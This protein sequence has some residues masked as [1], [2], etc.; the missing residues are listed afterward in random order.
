MS[1]QPQKRI[2]SFRRSVTTT[3]Q[4]CAKAVFSKNLEAVSRIIA[5]AAGAGAKVIFLPEASDFIAKAD[6]VA[7]LTKPLAQN[8]FVQGV[9]A[10]AK[11]TG[12]WVSV[13]VH[14]T[15]R[16]IPPSASLKSHRSRSYPLSGHTYSSIGL[17]CLEE[18]GPKT[19]V[20]LAP[21]NQFIWGHRVQLPQDPSLCTSRIL[22]VES[23]RTSGHIID[24]TSMSPEEQGSWNPTRRLREMS[25]MILL[26]HPLE[27]VSPP[28]FQRCHYNR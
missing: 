4:F 3:G 12:V 14:E 27:N 10:K 13:G 23:H 26:K 21:H 20:Q 7:S 15:V 6:E 17:L 1:T 18:L 22:Q 8:E 2:I 24:R 25:S 11:E 16:A 9:R 28:F 19:W 5:G